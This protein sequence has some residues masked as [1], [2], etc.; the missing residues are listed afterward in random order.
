MS[1]GV[2]QVLRAEKHSDEAENA[3]LEDANNKNNKDLS[4]GSDPG[5][6]FKGTWNCDVRVCACCLLEGKRL[7][8]IDLR[9][10]YL[11]EQS[12]EISLES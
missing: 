10:W 9:K 6:R 12:I 2:H 8:T 3:P 11:N 1:G 4:D 7:V 5:T